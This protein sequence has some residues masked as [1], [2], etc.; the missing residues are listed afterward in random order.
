MRLK[1]THR[2][3]ELRI[4][5]NEECVVITGWVDRRRDHGGLIFIDLRDL[6]GITQVRID[7]S[8]SAYAESK[9]LRNEFVVSFFGRVETRPEGMINSKLATGEIEVVADDIELLNSSKT[10]PFLIT[11]EN[12]ASEDLRLRYRYLDLRRPEMQKNILLRSKICQIVRNFFIERGFIEIE[13]PYLM[14]STPEGARDYLVP[15]RV[16]K[17]RFFALPQSPQTYKQLLMI[18]GFE[19]YFQIVRCFR[20]EDLRADRQPEF[21]QID[22][23]M[24]FIDENDIMTVVEALI[25]MIFKKILNI[26]LES[27]FPRLSYDEAMQRYGTDRPDVR[28]GLEIKDISQLVVKSEFKVFTESVKNNNIVAGICAPGCAHYSRKQI[29]DLTEW[30]KQR[31]AKGLVSIKIQN[32][33]WDSPL[34]KYFSAELRKE[35]LHY[36]NARN[37]DLLLLVAD[38]QRLVQPVLSELRLHIS[39]I[40]NLIDKDRFGL[41][42]VVDFPLFEYSE[43][44]GRYLA[45]HHPFTS[46]VLGDEHNISSE[47][48]KVKAR[49]YDLVLNGTEIAGGSIRIHTTKLQSKMFHALGIS[50]E[51][52]ENKFGYFLDALQYGAPPHG[53]IA[54]GLDRLIMILAGCSS[55]REVIAF[56]KT[57]SAMSLMDGAPSFVDPYQLEELG[58][59]VKADVNPL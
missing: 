30:V 38:N 20:D 8:S 45:R 2:C 21:T 26:D 24:S 39:R 13:T 42:W 19:R 54:F 43:E 6:W 59:E 32:D 5:N 51:E 16:W 29:D 41:T 1:R 57:A 46:P 7:P 56:P 35:I 58:L 17:G 15:S 11:G 33:D 52:A 31:Q 34:S 55:I 22:V 44:Q 37:G 14:K 4:A 12:N 3:D 36:F 28:F 18:S 48:D 23:E 53:G 49:A 10:P 50:K 9:K 40:E 27:P 47:P 25:V